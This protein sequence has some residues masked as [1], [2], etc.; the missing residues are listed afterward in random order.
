[1]PLII[2]GA[3]TV[4][5]EEILERLEGPGRDV[6]V[7]VSDESS[8][9]KL[10]KRG[11]KVAL[12]DVSDES[13]I[14]AAASKCFSAILITDAA[15][16]TRERSF[17]DSREDVLAAWTRAMSAADVKRVIWVTSGPTPPTPTKE[18]AVV[19]PGDP[20]LVKKV[21]E[22]DDAQTIE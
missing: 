17:A 1:M 9:G 8:V 15:T 7:F 14:E 11:F 20:D 13:H 4:S 22:L 18:V 10:K 5:G 19:A 21:L 12:G 3:D 2:V 6:R 16:D